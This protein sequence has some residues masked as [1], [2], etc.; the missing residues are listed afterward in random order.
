MK[1]L[2]PALILC[3]VFCFMCFFYEPIIMYA[4]NIYD[5]WFDLGIMIIPVIK[6]FTIFLLLNC[7][8]YIIVYY[9][10][11]KFS[12]NLKVYNI[13]LLIGFIVF[14]VTYIQG[15]YLIGNLPAL[16]GSTIAW[17]NYK[18]QDIITIIIWLIIIT[19]AVI[20]SKKLSMEKTIKYAT[21]ITLAI[22]GMLLAS[23]TTTM[24][25]TD[26]FTD[27]DGVFY[28]DD[29]IDIV[30]NNKNFY[31]FMLDAVDSQTFYKLLQENTEYQEMLNDFTY[32]PD[33]L[34]MYPFT[35]DSVPLMLSGFVNKNEQNFD[36]FSTE[37]LNNSPFF[38]KL[39]EDKYDINIYSTDLIWNGQRNFD[40]KNTKSINSI[41]VS[42]F[43]FMK[44]ELKYILFKYVPYGLK[45]Y[46]RI[47]D[48]NYDLSTD[49]YKDELDANYK[50]IV[51]NNQFTK[52]NNNQF[53]FFQTEGAHVPFNFD[54]NLNR[55][56]SGTGTYEKKIKSDLKLVNLLIQKLKDNDVYDNSVIIILA[57]HGY[58][59][60]GTS[61]LKRMNPL[62]MIKGFNEH[63]KLNISDAPISY[64]DL[65][66]T[67]EN[68]LNGKKS[69]ELFL[70]IDKK[71]KRTFINY[72]Y[73]VEEKMY[74]YTT[75]GPAWDAE[76]F[77]DTGIM[78]ELK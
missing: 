66:A 38:K 39:T 23:F 63:H 74:E 43:P 70:D 77:V 75:T 15:N 36:D 50:Y 1:K 72:V 40:L 68:L 20:S 58:N 6:I 21:Y 14:L 71:R 4:N 3:F 32:Y 35:R 41:S 55:I 56:K 29:N 78:Y 73:T 57:D 7:L 33:T 52:V 17:S 51:Q 67:Y 48:M 13:L 5:F 12:K 16:D 26:V 31:L 37:A 24:F 10:N 46:S 59:Y 2:I 62:F 28:T 53:K 64:V 69:T 61:I 76:K 11:K 34:S 19:I 42:L 27:K 60:N 54:E 22:F 44:Q 45:K 30:S 9:I 8:I 25:S 65:M 47:E 49:T 18:G